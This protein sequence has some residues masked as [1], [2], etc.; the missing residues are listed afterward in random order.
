MLCGWE[1]QGE[2]GV[3]SHFWLHE[4]IS[5][6]LLH[7]AFRQT[8]PDAGAFFASRIEWNEDVVSHFG[9]DTFSIVEHGKHDRS[10]FDLT[11][12]SDQRIF[13]AFQSMDTVPDQI[14]EYLF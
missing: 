6:V 1:T 14:D 7:D 5:I 12:Q 11:I 3:F 10:G 2:F 4:D 13:T 9:K 8:E